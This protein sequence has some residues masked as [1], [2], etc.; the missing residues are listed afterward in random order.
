MDCLVLLVP[1]NDQDDW[2]E[3]I[4]APGAPPEAETQT[5]CVQA[6]DDP[7]GST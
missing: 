3:D 1:V 7:A 5:E 2:G 4:D 6:P